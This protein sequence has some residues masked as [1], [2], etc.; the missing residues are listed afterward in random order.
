MERTEAATCL[1]RGSNGNRSC[2]RP[3]AAPMGANKWAS[4]WENRQSSAQHGGGHGYTTT[5]SQ[6]LHTQTPADQRPS[7]RSPRWLPPVSSQPGVQRFPG[8]TRRNLVQ[9]KKYLGAKEGRRKYLTGTGCP[10]WAQPYLCPWRKVGG[11]ATIPTA[12]QE[13]PRSPSSPPKKNNQPQQQQKRRKKKKKKEEKTHAHT[14]P[15]KL[16]FPGCLRLPRLPAPHM[17]APLAAPWRKPRRR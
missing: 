16:H 9:K 2:A 17:T 7:H 14:P 12:G 1:T 15:P 3:S 10:R 8:G 4:S 5:G 6:L 11:S 13:P